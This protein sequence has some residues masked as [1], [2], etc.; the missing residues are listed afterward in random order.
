M[1]RDAH[2]DVEGDTFTVDVSFDEEWLAAALQRAYRG[3]TVRVSVVISNAGPAVTYKAQALGGE[4]TEY[5][6]AALAGDFTEE[7]A[8]RGREPDNG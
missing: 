4:G 5:L 3:G 7:P 8:W 6:V 2:R 1:S